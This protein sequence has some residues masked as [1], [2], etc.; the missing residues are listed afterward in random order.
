MTILLL[1]LLIAGT[2]FIILKLDETEN[3]LYQIKKDVKYIQEILKNISD[4]K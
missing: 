4:S 3:T 2:G 1:L